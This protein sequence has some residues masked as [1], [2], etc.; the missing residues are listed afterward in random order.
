MLKHALTQEKV[1]LGMKE[2]A[3]TYNAATHREGSFLGLAL[4][5][6]HYQHVM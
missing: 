3:C 5:T 4:R 6:D 2:G 1:K